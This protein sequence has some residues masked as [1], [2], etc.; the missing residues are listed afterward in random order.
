MLV[1]KKAKAAIRH[2]RV[3][4]RF[5][6]WARQHPKASMKEKIA[7]LDQISDVEFLKDNRR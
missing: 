5:Q 4:D 2:T 1:E 7:K 3:A 6:N